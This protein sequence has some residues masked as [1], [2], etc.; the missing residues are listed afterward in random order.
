MKK[1]LMGL[2]L[3]LMTTFATAQINERW[4][5]IAEANE[6]VSIQVD[7]NTF[8]FKAG[9]TLDESLAFAR[10]KFADKRPGRPPVRYAT[11][12]VNLTSCL[13]GGGKYALAPEN[14]PLDVGLEI[15]LWKSK[16]PTMGDAIGD[17]LC[18][19]YDVHQT[20]GI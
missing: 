16:G 15:H 19:L 12:Y 2:A 8:S 11:G 7:I 5:I 1:L 10:I 13:N 14:V 20:R 6:G 9:K 18:A 17:A 3:L 4:M